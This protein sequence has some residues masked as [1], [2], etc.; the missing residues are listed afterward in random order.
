MP[1][2]RRRWTSPPARRCCASSAWR[3]RS[4]TAR[5]SGASATSARRTAPIATSSGCAAEISEGIEAAI[6]ADDLAVGDRRIAARAEEVDAAGPVHR[7]ATPGK[8][9]IGELERLRHELA[10]K[11]Q[12]LSRPDVIAETQ[13]EVLQR[14]GENRPPGHSPA[15]SPARRRTGKGG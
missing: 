6:H 8:R 11:T 15:R 12:D 1:R 9:A 7:A 10:E 5:S 2:P 3:S 13:E 14:P 4:T